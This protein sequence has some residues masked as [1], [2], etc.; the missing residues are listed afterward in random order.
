MR[1]DHLQLYSRRYAQAGD[2]WSRDP[3]QLWQGSI[4][5]CTPAREQ[6]SQMPAHGDQALMIVANL[7][8]MLSVEP[9]HG[10]SMSAKTTVPSMLYNS[11]AYSSMYVGNRMMVEH[12][13]SLS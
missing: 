2:M 12:A 4:A 13:G 8:S 11:A 6:T 3:R 7:I 10:L 5:G 1:P 9:T